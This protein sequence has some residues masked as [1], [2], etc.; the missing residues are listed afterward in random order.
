MS[1]HHVVT[2]EKAK[3]KGAVVGSGGGPGYRWYVVDNGT[4]RNVSN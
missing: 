4:M 3:C 2:E 1:I